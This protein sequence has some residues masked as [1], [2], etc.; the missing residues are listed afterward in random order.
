MTVDDL[1]KIQEIDTEILFNVV[2]ICERHNIQYFLMYGTLLGAV[3]HEGPIPWDDDVDI[4][5]TRE[6]YYKF[7]EVA[8][9][10]LDKRNEIC[11]MGSGSTK[12]ISEIKIGR[13]E[14]E[15][16]LSWAE[17]LNI[18]KQ[19][20]LDIFLI[21]YIKIYRKGINRCLEIIKRALEIGKLSWDEKRLILRSIDKSSHHGKIFYK[22]AVVLSHCIHII[23]GEEY[24]EKIIYHMYVD[25]K[26]ASGMLGVISTD[27]RIRTWPADGSTTRLKYEG[28]YLQVP[29]CYKKILQDKYGDYMKLPPENKRYRKHFDEWILRIK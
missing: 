8:P 11:I 13:K 17:D 19:I 3:R 1:K 5:M 25:E 12:Y 14:T 23:L 26:Q 16:C 29:S 21:D 10:E 15:Y 24:I 18:M 27:S 20:Q 9:K 2:D 22:S 28:R 6:N 7:L 4:G